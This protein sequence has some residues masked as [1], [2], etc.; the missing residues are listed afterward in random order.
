[1]GWNLEEF[2]KMCNFKNLPDSRMYQKYLCCKQK[3]AKFLAAESEKVWNNFWFTHK[4]I[5]IHDQKKVDAFKTAQ[6]QSET[7][8]EAAAQNLHSLAD[9]LCK[10]LNKVVLSSSLH[11]A[12]VRIEKII[13]KLQNEENTQDI[14]TALEDLRNY[15]EFKYISAFVNTI[16]HRRLL[17]TEYY[18]EFGLGKSN[19]I[20]VRFRGF[21]YGKPIEKYDDTLA[22]TIVN[23]YMIRIFD[24][25]DGVGS[26]IDTHIR[27]Q[28]S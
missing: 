4:E 28:T 17:D 23:V 14:V 9:I 16:K 25:I 20:G 21:E 18:G 19:T 13:N 15:D 5:N 22:E 1:M 3:K 11:E 10:T 7:Y 6:F 8:I 12:D 26:A 24:L 2:N 27:H